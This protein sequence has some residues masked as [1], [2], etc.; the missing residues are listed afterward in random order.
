MGKKKWQSL[1]GFGIIIGIISIFITGC[2]RK[3]DSLQLSEITI[4]YFPNITHAQALLMKAEGRLEERL[5]EEF[6]N[7]DISVKWVAFNAGPNEVQALFA[8]EIDI[9][10]MGPI[11]AISANVTSEGDIRVLAGASNAGAVLLVNEQADLT[12]AYQRKED[13]II[14]VSTSRHN[15]QKEEEKQ[16]F[17]IDWLRGKTIAV[18]QLGNTQHLCLLA[19]LDEYGL[20]QK[21]EGGDVTV[22]AVASSDMESMMLAEEIDA[23]FVAEPW[24]ARMENSGVARLAL[25]Y[26]EIWNNGDYPVALIVG[27]LGFVREQK[28]ATSIF[29]SVHQEITAL[30]QKEPEKYY[31]K[32]NEEMAKIS[33]SL[34]DFDVM[35]KAFSRLKITNKIERSALD[36]FAVVDKKEGFIYQLPGEDLLFTN[37]LSS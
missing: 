1:F 8:D 31:K 2:G 34:L 17:N 19:L 20:K 22:I 24:G 35:A 26:N 14:D 25:D 9:G 12:N 28:K 10:Y 29:L 27:R 32:I 13:K 15:L 16:K 4:G 23:A 7:Q 3:D 11:P 37:V 18:P 5:Q 30:L 21:S 36:A 33:G 6:D